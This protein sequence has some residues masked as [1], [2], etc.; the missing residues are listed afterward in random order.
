[1]HNPDF[2][3]QKHQI[4]PK[5]RER[6]GCVL[7]ADTALT[8]LVRTCCSCFVLSCQ[9]GGR[10]SFLLVWLRVSPSSHLLWITHW[11]LGQE[12]TAPNLSHV[13]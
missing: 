8:H 4:P 5:T 2:W 11:D 7:A 12:Q 3:V 9:S 10:G 13:G 1:M 6:G